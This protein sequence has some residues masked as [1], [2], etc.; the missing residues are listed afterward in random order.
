MKKVNI[1]KIKKEKTILKSVESTKKDN[2]INKKK[3]TSKTIEK[4]NNENTKKSDT[5]ISQSREEYEINTNNKEINNANS[6]YNF[7]INE[8]LKIKECSILKYGIK[9]ST[10]KINF[11]YCQ[12]CDVNLIHPICL[13]CARICHQQIGHRIR[14]MKE[15]ANIRC[16]CGE[17]MHKISN[18]RRTGKLI[19]A[20]ECPYLDLCEKSGLSTLY[21][22]EGKCVCEFC[23]RMC[24]YEGQGQPLEK[25]KEM[26]QVCECEDLNGILSHS[27]LKRIYKKFEDILLSKSNLIFGLEPV[28]FLNLLF[29]GKSSYESL[30]LNFEE[31]MQNFYE[32]NKKNLLN[33]KNNFTATNFYLSLRVFVKIIEKSN[34][35]S[36][37]YF[38]EEL[39]KKFSFKLI[40]NIFNF[41]IFQ[42][43]EIFWNFL[44]GMLFLYN[45]INI[46][47][48]IMRLGEYNLSDLEN[49]SPL[50]RKFIMMN[51]KSLYS[52]SSE[53]IAFFIKALNNL[54]KNEIKSV[55]AY[56]VFIHICE[57]LEKLSSCYLLNTANM[58]MFCFAFEEMFEYFK[59][60]N[61]YKKQ[62]DLFYIVANMFNYFIYCY[63]DSNISNF[64][65]DNK[66]ENMKNVGFAFLN[67]QL[68]CLITRHIIRIMYF[69]LTVIKYNS[70]TV[71]YKNKCSDILKRGTKI[72]SLLIET[73]DYF[74]N[75]NID[76]ITSDNLLKLLL[77]PD[78]NATIE[79]IKDEIIIIEDIYSKFYIFEADKKDII[80]EI[81]NSLERLFTIGA[82]N[83]IKY[84]I[85]KTNYLNV[86]C[87]LFYIIKIKEEN[88]EQEEMELVNKL[89][90]NIFNF[91]F[92]FI[93]E[94][95]NNAKII[96]SNYI[97][98]ALIKL[99]EAYFLNIL[100]LYAKCFDLITKN[101]G[102]F[103]NPITII[104]ILYNYLINYK[105]NSSKIWKRQ[106]IDFFIDDVKIIDQVIFLFLII[107]IKLFLQMKLLYPFSCEK[108]L[109]EM[110]LNFLENF[111][112]SSLIGYNACLLLLLLNKIFDSS[113]ENDREII[114]KFIHLDKLRN[115]L[116]DTNILLDLR[117]QILIFI[118]KFYA[119]LYFK[120]SDN[121]KKILRIQK[122]S[123]SNNDSKS[124]DKKKRIVHTKMKKKI[125]LNNI[126]ILKVN[127]DLLFRQNDE[128]PLR[129]N[130]YLNAIGQDQDAFSFLKENAL[131]T[132]YQ[133]PA[134][135][136]TF[137]Y[138]LKKQ[139]EKDIAI[140]DMIF[141]LFEEEIKKFK[142]INEKN[143][144]NNKILKYFIK[145]IMF[146]F[147][148]I[149][150]NKFCNT[151]EYNGK[152]ILRIY[153]ALIKM[154]YLK[155]FFIENHS[156]LNER[157][158]IEFQNFDLSGFL[159][160]TNNEAI[161]DFY[162]LKERQN[163]PYD[164]TFLW[165]IFQ[166]HF[167]DYIQYPD[168]LN[169][170]NNFPLGEI[171][172]LRY[173]NIT[174]EIDILDEIYSNL[175]KKG[176]NSIIKRITSKIGQN[177]LM[178]NDNNKSQKG[179]FFSFSNLSLNGNK[180]DIEEININE[181]KM[182][183][184]RKKIN[185]IFD[186][187]YNEK[188]KLK[189]N[190]SSLLSSL[191]ELCSEYEVNY[192]KLL[193]CLIINIPYELNEYDLIY[194]II[195]YKLLFLS[196]L[197]TQ[198]DI[199][200]LMGRKDEKEPGFLVNYCNFLYCNVIRTFIDDFNLDF[201]RYKI[202]HINIFCIS[203]ILK[204]IC[205]SH[206]NFFQEKLTNSINFYFTKLE[207]CLMSLT[208]K[209]GFFS[210]NKSRSIIINSNNNINTQ[211]DFMSFF[212]F[213]LNVLHKFLVITNKAKERRHIGYLYDLFYSI[214]ELLK[215]MVQG[216]KKELLWKIKNDVAKI[217]H[218][219]MTLFTFKTFVFLDKDILFNDSLISGPA[220]KIR[221]L[222]I[223]FF[224]VLLEEKTN[225]ELQKI[226]MKFLTINNV[227]ES[228]NLTLKNYFIEQTKNDTNYRSYFEDYNEKQIIQREIIF[229]HTIFSFFKYN[230]FNSDLLKSSQ[231]F[232]LANNYY[233]YIKKIS[234]N[235]K[236]VEAKYLIKKV[237]ILSESEAKKKFAL[238]N[239]KIIKN[240]DI[241]PINLTNEK[242]RTIS[243]SYVEHYYIIKFF[244]M[245]TKVVEIRL[246]HEQRNVNVIFTVP[247]GINY[248]TNMT[249]KEFIYNVDRSNEN[250]KKCELVRSVP[251]F[252][253]EIEYF[254][255]IK[256]SF[257]S[258][259]ILSID[260]IYIQI[261][262]YLYATGL[263]MIMLFTLEGYT[264]IEPVNESS[265][266]IR[267]LSSL[268]STVRNLIEI[269]SYIN[270]SIDESIEKYGL[271]YNFIN[272]G[273]VILNGLFILSWV[274]V[275]LPLY[276]IFDK[277]KFMEEKKITREEDLTI[278][279]KIYIS[280][281]QTILGRDYINSLIY[282]FIISLIGAIMKRGEIIYAFILLAITDLNKTLKGIALSIKEKGSDL[283]ASFLLLV[284][285]VYFYSNIGFF[286]FNDHFEAD[287]ENDI[288][289]N[290]CLSLSFCF[291]TNF[292]AG[293]RAR[294][295]AGDQMVRISFERHTSSYI[296]RLFHDISYFLICI[297]IMIDLTFG[298]VLG[299]FSEKREEERKHDNDK[300][301]HC[302]IC[303]ITR[304]IIEKKR[305]NFNV[306]REQKHNIWNYVE[307]MIYLKFSDWHE[308]STFNSFAKL[309]LEKKNVCFLPTCQDNFD[310][311]EII[312]ENNKE[313]NEKSK[314]FSE[315]NSDLEK[316]EFLNTN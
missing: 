17:K 35:S 184:I 291:L 170:E 11:G 39:V 88:L 73:D 268:S 137:N 305:E 51:N 231:E 232:K 164:F 199:I 172:Y 4:S 272:L 237:D 69:T 139:Q 307:Y 152:Q 70:L 209:S 61:T 220:F 80:R 156:Y 270:Q 247:S 186:Y 124:K 29:L 224:I 41:I 84:S 134:K 76:N 138:Y 279:N 277:F 218:N 240:N 283:V 44:S 145:G 286:F 189:I 185:K 108:Y 226:I 82:N 194:K 110:L 47:F 126:N 236:S 264:K 287:I 173:D 52:E 46:G 32:L 215:E 212:N 64:I 24:G 62:I 115:D 241:A 159:D 117:T 183:D 299:T 314:D 79:K 168:S 228:I 129:N 95:E 187:Y 180:A 315:E 94:N 203:K 301:N 157:K 100:K 227:L 87:K 208:M 295:G 311:E 96:C 274:T 114:I 297:I 72:F 225:K 23:Y 265:E 15:Q 269:P 206:N 102:F 125:S 20:K 92:Y 104:E 281:V 57:I 86:L 31:M 306:H 38:S 298:I 242:E 30:F 312:E 22:V 89:I 109:K 43:T 260:F 67:N 58:T 296:Y 302:F 273:F 254:K 214:I 49:L 182:N 210:L 257:L 256:V 303:H 68:G 143:T 101:G 316:S 248:L 162:I 9:I 167:L 255:N 313:D 144:D 8:F 133:Y 71:E 132:N 148:S 282:M 16:G 27:D 149:I 1:K 207:E 77:L 310:E 177:T 181:E 278:L 230:Y 178:M 66:S 163:S 216:N 289:D 234:I 74:I 171:T 45:K 153:E 195:F 112:Y 239:K 130:I 259:I 244:E 91:L 271:I 63:N 105:K 97:L 166:K 54:L 56:D 169:L 123:N 60:Q 142:Y 200:N 34:N 106:A 292:D 188:R 48:N 309:N 246:P 193:L 107:I 290:Y 285:I 245:I 161:N 59:K 83:D 198:S 119:S 174:D 78:R 179:K 93:E 151:C 120:H 6:T 261:I 262:M 128:E 50:Q 122:E 196:S 288:K 300:I 191:S 131:I 266:R 103:C 111:E 2:K 217:K 21:V 141:N 238:F 99:P 5:M 221:L 294:G 197:D 53:Q 155:I 3:I 147:C 150:K 243:T 85:L 25:E 213:L 251:L 136:L 19:T 176:G 26:L 284:F 140:F 135:A 293:I 229:D 235:E 121:T 113:E 18:Y 201:T 219:D 98:N 275:K 222:L 36:L 276:Y 154:L 75:S 146:P 252:Q 263:L 55:E 160:K 308:L 190:N 14:E 158:K 65:F 10:E 211:E 7:A 118:F 267:R 37:A 250:S 223:S 204:L 90:S 205:E 233:I 202:N 165:K 249:K 127:I 175:K 304:E 33:L 280:I 42:D 258:R 12:T 28:Q 253:L 116:E 40:S 13:E 192:R 81:N